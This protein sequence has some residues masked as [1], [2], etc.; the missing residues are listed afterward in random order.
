MLTNKKWN[1]IMNKLRRTRRMTMTEKEINFQKKP[2]RGVDKTENKCYSVKAV[3][4][5][6]QRNKLQKS[7]KDVDKEKQTW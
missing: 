4:E 6:G 7:K 2:K 5:N 3:F 1:A